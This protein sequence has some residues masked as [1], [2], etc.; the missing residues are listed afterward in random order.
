MTVLHRLRHLTIQCNTIQFHSIR[1]QQQRGSPRMIGIA[2]SSQRRLARMTTTSPWMS[3]IA[4]ASQR[5]RRLARMGSTTS[6]QLCAVTSVVTPMGAQW[7]TVARLRMVSMN[8]ERP[9]LLGIQARMRQAICRCLQG[10]HHG[11]RSST[12]CAAISLVVPVNWARAAASPTVR[13]K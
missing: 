5:R 13:V 10:S 7:A 4:G 2:R 9:S 8:S 11:S 12:R 1:R 3:G 6:K